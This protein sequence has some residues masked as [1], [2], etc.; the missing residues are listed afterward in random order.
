MPRPR[1]PQRRRQQARPRRPARAAA[2]P[3]RRRGTA[4]ELE[5]SG[6]Q[7]PVTAKRPTVRVTKERGFNVQTRETGPRRRKVVV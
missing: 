7:L 1:R 3:W 6:Q 5:I 4:T 2:Q